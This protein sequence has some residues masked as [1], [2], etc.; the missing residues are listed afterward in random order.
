MPEDKGA[1]PVNAAIFADVPAFVRGLTF[2][3]LSADVVAQ[4]RTACST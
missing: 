1:S 3:D 4:A 2:A